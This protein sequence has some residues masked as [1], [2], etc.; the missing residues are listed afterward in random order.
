[1]SN[2]CDPMDCS[3]P[4]SLSIGFSMQEY[5]DGLPFPSP[6]TYIWN[7]KTY[8]CEPICREAIEM[9]TWRT[10]FW[11]EAEREEV[12]QIKR[13]VFE[14]VCN[15]GDL[16]LIPESGTS[17]GEGNNYPLQYPCPEN[18]RARRAWWVTV[19]GVP[20]SWTQLSN[21][22]NHLVRHY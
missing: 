1:M 17:P 20:K 5:W 14:S 16:G 19:H 13:T 15:T 11:T 2:S 12:G 8:I 6:N 18:S 7:L 9:Q 3:L 22:E 10:D 4:G 21:L